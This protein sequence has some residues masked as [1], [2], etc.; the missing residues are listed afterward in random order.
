MPAYER[1]EGAV[2]C[3]GFGASVAHDRV[4]S[5]G[6]ESGC[7]R[8]Q[9]PGKVTKACTYSRRIKKHA[10]DAIAKNQNIDLNNDTVSNLGKP[11]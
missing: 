10:A 6:K 5:F 9:Q 11:V 8:N 2:D 3:G 7:P 1:D 4:E